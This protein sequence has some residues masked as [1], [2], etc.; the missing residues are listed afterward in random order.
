M[1]SVLPAHFRRL[2]KAFYFIER[3]RQIDPEF[4][5]KS[6]KSSLRQPQTSFHPLKRTSKQARQYLTQSTAKNKN[7]HT[8]RGKK[9]ECKR[10][11]KTKTYFF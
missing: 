1:Q 9:T 10:L 7:P 6:L 5:K 2:R 4:N 8:R 3:L 11:K